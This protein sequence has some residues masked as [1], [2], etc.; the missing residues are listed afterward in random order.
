MRILLANKYYYLRSGT[1]RYLFNVTRLLESQ[2]HTVGIFSMHHPRNQPTPFHKFFVPNI[3][4]YSKRGVLGQLQ[5]ALRA[6]WYPLAAHNIELL[7]NEFKPD[8]VQLH[9]IYHQISPSILPA[10][11]KHGIPIIH[12][13][14]DYKLLCPNYLLHT[15]GDVCERCRG[16]KYIQA[17]RYRCLHGSLSWSLAAATEMTIHKQMRVYEN[18]IARFTCPSRFLLNKAIDFGIARNSLEYLPNFLFLDDLLPPQ[19]SDGQYALYFG[20][21]AKEKG[22]LTLL[23]ASQMEP[24]PLKIVGEGPMISEVQ[25]AIQQYQ[26]RHVEVAG[27]HQGAALAHLISNARY[28]IV[29]SE[30]YEVFGQ[31][32]IEAFAHNKPV[33]ASSIGGIPEII[34]EGLDGLLVQPKDPKA[35]AQTIRWLWDNPKVAIQM[36]KNGR[37]KVE[38]VYNS[39]IHYHNLIQIYQQVIN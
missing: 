2:G 16:Q 8:L 1:E 24:I 19:S 9:N 18:N 22:L 7:I 4:Y 28:V 25:R 34:T 33:I 38:E 26:M 39:D 10:I 12:R 36:G 30:W 31:I 27:Y 15:S 37:K 11:R 32:I 6:I 14:H 13:L 21:L 3:E 20:R 23:S 35:L 5:S 29:P 17:I